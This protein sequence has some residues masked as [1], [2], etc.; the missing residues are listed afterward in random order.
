MQPSTNVQPETAEEPQVAPALTP[1]ATPR[2]S[3]VHGLSVDVEDYYHVEAFAD[4]ITPDQWPGFASRVGE[5]VRRVLD[6]LA[7]FDVRATFFILGYVAEREPEVVRRIQDARH[8]VACHSF[9]HRCIFRMTPEEFRADT[10]RGRKAIEDAGGRRVEGYRAP[11]FSIVRPSLWAL[12][13]LAEEGFFY[14]SSVFPV[15]H[16]VYGIPEAPRFL[17]NWELGTGRSIYEL[18]PM[19]ARLWG[20]NWPVAGGG[21]LRILP[22]WYTRWGVER[23]RREGN[24]SVMYFHPWELDPEQPR[25]AGSWK[26]RLRHY[27]NLGEMEGRLRQLLRCA[28]FVPLQD[29]LRAQLSIGAPPAITPDSLQ[30]PA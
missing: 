16:D 13:V 14:D 27:R 20:R 9:N 1:E 21:Y 5:S 23:V 4:R 17:Y 12:E 24:S 6:L 15:H 18:P 3:S 10:Q 22:M 19:T 7:G 29:V 11:T 8:E 25:L 26:S 2:G 28:R 30:S